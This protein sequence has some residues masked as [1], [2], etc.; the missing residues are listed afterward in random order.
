MNQGT[1]NTILTPRSN[2][3][4]SCGHCK[5]SVTMDSLKLYPRGPSEEPHIRIPNM[6][7]T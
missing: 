5:L 3:T 2:E 6:K 7:E 1:Q 4:T